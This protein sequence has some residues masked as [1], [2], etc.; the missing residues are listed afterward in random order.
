MNRVLIKGFTP[1][2]GNVS[3]Y[4]FSSQDSESLDG[5][6]Y[7]FF[8]EKPTLGLEITVLKK[9][10]LDDE[11]RVQ[12]KVNTVV[13]LDKSNNPQRV[14]LIEQDNSVTADEILE[15][16]NLLLKYD[17]FDFGDPRNCYM[18][19]LNEKINLQRFCEILGGSMNRPYKFPFDDSLSP[20]L[21]MEIIRE[22]FN[23][24][25]ERSLKKKASMLRDSLIKELSLKN[26]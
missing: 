25:E 12:F 4:H 19:E 1:F 10:K 7:L 23:I 2:P 9:V 5:E 16:K 6:S 17:E 22:R 8:E 21:K 13:T 3:T 14:S 26:N 24:Y 18:K 20:D 11:V 15:V